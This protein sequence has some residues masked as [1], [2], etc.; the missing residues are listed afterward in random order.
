MSLSI[1]LK[2]AIGKSADNF[3]CLLMHLMFKSDTSNFKK[4][5]SVYPVEANMVW[6]LK[7]DCSYVDEAKK[8][9]VDFEKIEKRAKDIFYQ[10]SKAYLSR[11]A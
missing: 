6:L 9:E 2:N 7:N 5:A 11:R 4:L 3:T 8:T 10:Q 1:D